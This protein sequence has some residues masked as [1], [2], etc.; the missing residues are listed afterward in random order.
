MYEI[1]LTPLAEG[2]IQAAVDW[3]KEHHSPVEAE[4]WYVGI[5][6][7]IQ[8][9]AQMPMR[10]RVVSVSAFDVPVRQLLYG[11]SSKPTHRVLFAVN[12][13][14]ETVTVYRVLHTSQKPLDQNDSIH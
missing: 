7:A 12:E 9:L 8:S 13:A 4:V 1:E 6:A 5:L 14:T 10:C 11:V 3:W 2:D